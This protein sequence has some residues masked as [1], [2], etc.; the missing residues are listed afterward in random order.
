MTAAAAHPADDAPS[1]WIARFAPLVPPGSR[2]LD[3]ACGRGRHSRYFAARLCDVVAV[4]RDAQALAALAGVARVT[5]MAVDLEAGPWP[6]A[7][8]RFDAI[9]VANY[10]HR[11]LLAALLDALEA[12]GTWLYETFA[13]GN[14]AY[15]K[16]ANPNFLLS[17]DELL[18][19]TRDRLTVVAF[20]QGVVHGARSA[21]MQRIAA[22]GRG[23]RW[24]PPLPGAGETPGPAVAR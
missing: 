16:P 10:L 23:R 17:P 19:L 9:V 13:A 12:H 15:G 2:V 24:P 1:G 7:G 3:L 6:L 11:P 21:V 20:E 14:E 8:E 5:T 4:D 18:M 22:V